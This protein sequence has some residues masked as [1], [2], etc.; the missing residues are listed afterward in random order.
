MREVRRS[1]LPPNR[2]Q[3]KISLYLTG[4]CAAGIEQHHGEYLHG[5]SEHIEDG[6]AVEPVCPAEIVFKEIYYEV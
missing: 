3:R 2:A 4:T 1:L 5:P 6:V